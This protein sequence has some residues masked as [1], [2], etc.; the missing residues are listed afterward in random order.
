MTGPGPKPNGST[1]G[2]PHV[3]S[4]NSAAFAS[5]SSVR[6]CARGLVIISEGWVGAVRT[7]LP[8]SFP[9]N[10]AKSSALLI[11]AITAGPE[12]SPL[13]PGDQGRAKPMSGM[14]PGSFIIATNRVVFQPRPN[15]PQDSSF[16][17]T[18]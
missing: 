7:I 12:T 17:L 1:G 6:R 16:A 13:V 9:L 15:G 3:G 4:G 18:R 10:L 2:L 5:S 11:T 8:R 14:N